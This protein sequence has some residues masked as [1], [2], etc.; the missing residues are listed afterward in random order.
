MIMRV[1]KALVELRTY[2][3][4]AGRR[5]GCQGNR[6]DVSS[7]DADALQP[8]QCVVLCTSKKVLSRAK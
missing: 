6:P 7:T 8:V 5:S 2:M 3:N 4:C 1:L